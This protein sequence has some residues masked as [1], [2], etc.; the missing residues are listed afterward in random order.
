MSRDDVSCFDAGLIYVSRLCDSILNAKEDSFSDGLQLELRHHWSQ[1]DNL[2]TTQGFSQTDSNLIRSDQIISVIYFLHIETGT[3]LHKD[4]LVNNSS[5]DWLLFSNIQ[6]FVKL[7]ILY[8]FM[9]Y[10]HWSRVAWLASTLQSQHN[11]C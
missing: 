6:Y 1:N 4:L 9:I 5:L 11:T 7:F 2:Y 10:R 3:S 8:K